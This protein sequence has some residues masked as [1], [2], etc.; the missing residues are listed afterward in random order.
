MSRILRALPWLLAIAL[1]LWI[2]ST[3]SWTETAAALRNLNG[4]EL[5]ALAVANALV[6]VAIAGRWWLLL[7]AQG[8]R[9]P[10]RRVFG[11]RLAAFGLS[12]F[13]PGPHV[14]G[15]PLQVILVEREG[16]PRPD[17]LAAVALDKAL[18]FAVNFT[19]LLVGLLFILRWRIVPAESGR[20][21]I[22]GAAVLLALPLAYLLASGWGRSPLGW[23]FERLGRLPPM[24]LSLRWRNTMASF[25][26]AAAA[27][28]TQIAALFREAPLYLVA[29]LAL[30]VVGWLLMLVEYW[31]MVAFLGVRMDFRQLITTLTA[32]RVAIL[33]LLPAGL[34][35]LEASQTVA[36]SAVGLNPSVGLA[37]SLL[38]RARD[39][40]L[41]AVGLWWGTR[42][43]RL[44]SEPEGDV[45]EGA[46]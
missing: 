12:Y 3:V 18:E 27:G 21:A 1:V 22:G 17:A 42:Q 8:H 29:A 25:A 37:A 46:S 2:I 34:G 32:A 13:T 26:R 19:F 10:F 40:A 30:S 28:E 5:L 31:L 43:V 38:I 20:Q 39:T 24:S 4:W 23:L 36:F 33:L 14:G 6:L 16:V 41:A 7:V 44:G 15:E 35:A 45:T 11:F 9:L